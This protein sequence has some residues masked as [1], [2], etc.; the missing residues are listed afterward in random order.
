MPHP[1]K[2]R[3]IVQVAMRSLINLTQ[4]I[5][6]CVQKLELCGSLHCLTCWHTRT[7]WLQITTS[8]HIWSTAISSST[9]PFPQGGVG[10]ED[11]C[12]ICRWWVQ[13]S[14][15]MSTS[16]HYRPNKLCLTRSLEF[17]TIT[18][19]ISICCIF[20]LENG[21]TMRLC[22][23]LWKTTIVI[24]HFA[25]TSS[26]LFTIPITNFSQLKEKIFPTLWGATILY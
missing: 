17:A 23:F 15:I 1:R 13:H 22:P 19:T 21:R 16:M 4:H 14:R 11:P 5:V 20:E 25:H 10:N 3:R 26:W 9:L 7:F 12:P 6:N 2:L 18:I 24:V 8:G